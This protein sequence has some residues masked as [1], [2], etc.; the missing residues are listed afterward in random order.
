MSMPATPTNRFYPL[1]DGRTLTWSHCAMS[2]ATG[3]VMAEEHA[4][5]HLD[6]EPIPDDALAE[7]LREHGLA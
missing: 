7:L 5:G 2:N 4:Y 3:T 6:G 1:P